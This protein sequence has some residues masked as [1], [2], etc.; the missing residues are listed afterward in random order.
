MKLKRLTIRGLTT[1]TG[2]DPVDVRFDELSGGLVAIV[3]RNGSGKT[4]LL[5]AVPAALY[6]TMPDRPGGLYEYMSG[7]DAFVRAIFVD[8][9]GVEFEVRLNVDAETKK[10]EQHVFVDGEPTTSGKAAENKGLIREYFGSY[11]LLL[12]SVFASQS[13]AG[14][15]L[16]MSKRD[17]KTLMI[18][19]LG[20]K[21]YEFYH[22][23]SK[24]LR[25]D[26]E[27]ELAEARGR[28]STME[29]DLEPLPGLE[30]ELG[31]ATKDR[32]LVTELLARACE[33][34]EA[35]RCSLD[36]AKRAEESVRHLH[37]QLEAA[38]RE[39]L[40]ATQAHE[41][42]QDAVRN[43]EARAKAQ[44]ATLEAKDPDALERHA[45][46]RYGKA[47]LRLV[48]RKQRLTMAAANAGDVAE[49]RAEVE[50]LKG[51]QADLLA[52]EA[53]L[54]PLRQRVTEAER[55]LSDAEHARDR[56]VQEQHHLTLQAE[57]MT[58]VPCTEASSWVAIE[59][60][61]SDQHLVSVTGSNRALSGE[62][63]L[64]AG[65]REAASK[66]DD[67]HQK[68]LEASTEVHAL[69]ARVDDARE[70][71]SALELQTDPVRLINLR[72]EIEDGL[73]AIAKAE[74]A[75][76]AQV[77]LESI[78]TERASLNED[79]AEVHAAAAELRETI[80]RDRETI[81]RERETLAAEAETKAQAAETALDEAH[82]RQA[83][84]EA[85]LRRAS[86]DV[87][88]LAA[89]EAALQGIQ[90]DRREAEE[91]AARCERTVATLTTKVEDLRTKAE[92]L[93]GLRVVVGEFEQDLGDWRFLEEAFGP[94]G[95]QALEIDAAGPSVTQLV[96]QL[97]EACYGPRFSI[98]FETLREK[99]SKAGEYSE[100]FDVKVYDGG[101]ERGVEALSGG[102]R[103]V[104]G[105]AI[106]LALAIFNSQRSGVKW[107]TLFRDETA[108]ALDPQNAEAYVEMLRRALELG[109]LDQVLFVS[110]QR[111]IWERADV[112]LYVEGGRVT[113]EGVS[114]E[115]ELASV[116]GAA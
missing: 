52:V 69:T 40:S 48:E 62:C 61:E 75:K 115:S 80:A 94:D 25:S 86:A 54:V 20:L 81:E 77:E 105:E 3:G 93:E 57:Q 79:L 71:L 13:K 16:R 33:K 23:R 43:V 9:W 4:T 68:A 18:E 85:E 74:W 111:E 112:R 103:V 24:A 49:H 67:L 98:A 34:E 17:R 100:A 15:F 104:I 88:N 58:E 36:E 110:H 97:L 90:T 83:G 96:N 37:E 10:T 109:G 42:A 35:A 107:R 45:Q 1:F 95:L 6:R 32:A 41:A 29:A 51:E 19:L 60:G 59:D 108:G 44:L 5:S 14:D 78:A 28:V 116:G 63:P 106:G 22:E 89:A 2:A 114:A 50:R 12:A 99:K 7:K 56:I 27:L 72:V 38:K 53:K 82:D 39:V 26:K 64:L 84:A 91:S 8:Q 101:V 11:E 113:P 76:D 30:D 65:A 31:K 87:G 66:N 70:E 73:D 46:E 102:E 55:A 47:L 92:S 21:A